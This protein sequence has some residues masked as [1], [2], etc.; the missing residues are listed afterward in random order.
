MNTSDFE[1]RFRKPISFKCDFCNEDGSE[2]GYF[3][4]TNREGSPVDE[5]MKICKP[6]W[7]SEY[8]SRC[9]YCHTPFEKPSDMSYIDTDKRFVCKNCDLRTV[10]CSICKEEVK[11]SECGRK[12]LKVKKWRY[13]CHS[14]AKNPE[15]KICRMC[16]KR[17]SGHAVE[18]RYE[19]ITDLCGKCAE[20]YSELMVSQDGRRRE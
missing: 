3:V 13:L 11:F 10:E 2:R 15:I 1:S 20:I 18:R 4:R 12:Q 14:C 16:W 6:C 7:N 5:C 17:T 19:T 9:Y 8:V